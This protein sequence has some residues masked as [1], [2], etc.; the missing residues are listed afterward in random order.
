[1]SKEKPDSKT[2]YE[3]CT[4]MANKGYREITL[5]YGTDWVG[6][7]KIRSMLVFSNTLNNTIETYELVELKGKQLNNGDLAP[8]ICKYT[9]RQFQEHQRRFMINIYIKDNLY[10]YVHL[11]KQQIPLNLLKLLKGDLNYEDA[12]RELISDIISS[13]KSA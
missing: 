13:F 8:F 10:N 6:N 9:P 7:L 4:E 3:I 2:L 12:L 11:D 5:G 1:M